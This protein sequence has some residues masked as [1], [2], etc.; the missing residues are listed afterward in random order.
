MCRALRIIYR[1]PSSTRTNAP[2]LTNSNLIVRRFDTDE[3]SITTAF[4][5]A[6]PTATDAEERTE[7]DWVRRTF[8]DVHM[9]SVQRRPGIVPLSGLW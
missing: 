8:P 3:I 1:V 7:M 9:D 4:R 2:Q 5:A 6:F